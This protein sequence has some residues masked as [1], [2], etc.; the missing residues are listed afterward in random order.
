M[1]D[2]S[3]GGPPFFAVGN[4]ELENYVDLDMSVSIPCKECGKR[5]MP[6]HGKTDGKE[7]ELLAFIH[8]GDCKKSWLVGVEGKR[9]P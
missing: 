7:N 1:E 2:K 9:L 8:C 6:Q 4:Y 5:L 3:E